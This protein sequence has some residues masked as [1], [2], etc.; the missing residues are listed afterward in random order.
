MCLKLSKKLIE[1]EILSCI[2][3]ALL[4]NKLNIY[5]YKHIQNVQIYYT[6]KSMYIYTCIYMVCTIYKKEIRNELM[7]PQINEQST[8]TKYMYDFIQ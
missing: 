7:K 5:K 3:K 1:K 4:T 8:R 2:G 6:C